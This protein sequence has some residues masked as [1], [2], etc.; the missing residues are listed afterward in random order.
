MCAVG[1][2]NVWGDN[3]SNFVRISLETAMGKMEQLDLPRKSIQFDNY[4]T[5][6]EARRKLCT[7]CTK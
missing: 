3:K 1:E 2:P 6:Y 5:Q 7:M 4:G